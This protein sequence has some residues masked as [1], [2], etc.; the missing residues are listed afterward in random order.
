MRGLRNNEEIIRN[1]ERM[2]DIKLNLIKFQ[3]ALHQPSQMDE[4]CIVR[5]K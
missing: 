3:S 5:W 1:K 2:Q 4:G